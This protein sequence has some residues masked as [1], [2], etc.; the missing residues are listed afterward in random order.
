MSRRTPRPVR[1]AGGLVDR[2]SPVLSLLVLVLLL[3]GASGCSQ[4]ARDLSGG[5]RSGTNPA[6]VPDTVQP[7]ALNPDAQPVAFLAAADWDVPGGHFYTQTNGM[8][9]LAS[10]IGFAVTDAEGIPFWTEFQRLG[11]ANLLGYPL[12]GRLTFQN[13]ATQVFQRGILQWNAQER[14]VQPMNV[15]HLLDEAGKTEWLAQ[16]HRV[17]ARLGSDFDQG[18]QG[19]A[20]MA[21]RLALLSGNSALQSKFNAAPDPVALYGLPDSRIVD[22]GD[23]LAIRFQRNVL[24]VWKQ[25]VPW[26]KAGEATADNSG[27]YAIEAG[28]IPAA[29]LATEQPVSAPR[30]ANVPGLVVQPASQTP[31]SAAAATPTAG[32]SSASSIP[33]GGVLQVANTNGD[34]VWLRKT[35]K[36][37]DKL[38]A[39]P[40]GALMKSLNEQVE[41]EGLKWQKVQAPDGSVGWIPEKFLRAMR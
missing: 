2:S 33:A 22:Q 25:D 23:H 3:V 10:A 7:V 26:A 4:I 24:R 1:V 31:A 30:R 14:A 6:R 38:N 35:T 20:V 34:G 13:R 39:W 36:L 21:A 17:P 15:L 27:A 8:P 41:A 12:S 29:A 28:L 40:E 32:A 19:S 11:G 37:E 5:P 16:T 9:A 18:R